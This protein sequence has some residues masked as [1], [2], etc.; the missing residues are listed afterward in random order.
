MIDIETQVYAAVEAVVRAE[1][2]N[3]FMVGEYV[4][5]PTSFPCVSFVETANAVYRNG[6][7]SSRYENQTA[8]TYEVNVYSNKTSGKKAECKRIIALIDEKMDELG[9]TRRSLDTIPNLSDASIYRMVGRY[10]AIVDTNEI[11]YRR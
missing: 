4:A 3:I 5:S 6:I 11:I 7:S 9:F 2:P 8:V 10:R 1:Y